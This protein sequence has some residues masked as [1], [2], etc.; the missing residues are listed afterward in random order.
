MNVGDSQMKKFQGTHDPDKVHLIVT[1]NPPWQRCEDRNKA[2]QILL[3]NVVCERSVTYSVVPWT[4][5]S[6]IY[7]D[8]KKKQVALGIGEFLRLGYQLSLVIDDE[9]IPDGCLVRDIVLQESKIARIELLPPVVD[10]S[11]PPHEAD[12][13][14]DRDMEVTEEHDMEVSQLS[15]PTGLELSVA[16]T[17]K[18]SE[19]GSDSQVEFQKPSELLGTTY[20]EESSDRLA[21]WDYGTSLDGQSTHETQGGLENWEESAP[22]LLT[23]MSPKI[24]ARFPVARQKAAALTVAQGEVPSSITD[25]IENRNL[26]DRIVYS[27]DIDVLWWAKKAVLEGVPKETEKLYFKSPVKKK[28]YSCKQ[29]WHMSGKGRRTLWFRSPVWKPFS[30]LEEEVT[31]EAAERSQQDG[32]PT[33]LCHW[34]GGKIVTESGHSWHAFPEKKMAV[35]HLLHCL[36]WCAGSEGVVTK[37]RDEYKNGKKITCE[38]FRHT[39]GNRRGGGVHTAALED[40]WLLLTERRRMSDGESESERYRKNGNFILFHFNES[41]S[42]YVGFIDYNRAARSSPKK[43]NSTFFLKV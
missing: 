21:N 18:L 42:A 25:E 15:A 41:G 26:A 20:S 3:G 5:T 14:E 27:R 38:R 24:C 1:R 23:Q 11:L 10:L 7:A 12:S 37:F 43:K 28:N 9:V 34:I 30:D 2:P 17:M 13:T 36:I 29:V 32:I 35:A 31:F 6:R 33:K 4:N 39:P 22:T 19:G 40:N 16:G 8:V